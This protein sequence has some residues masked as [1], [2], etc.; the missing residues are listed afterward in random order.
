VNRSGNQRCW[1]RVLPVSAELSHG[2]RA[3]DEARTAVPHSPL[4]AHAGAGRRG[5][6]GSHGVPPAPPGNRTGI[7]QRPRLWE[8]RRR[9]RPV[10]GP[11]SPITRPELSHSRRSQLGSPDGKPCTAP[12]A[13][14]ACRA[15]S[16]G[17]VPAA[18][19]P[20]W[21]RRGLTAAS[22]LPH[23]HERLYALQPHEDAQVTEAL[24]RTWRELIERPL[25]SEMACHRFPRAPFRRFPRDETNS[26]WGT[27]MCAGYFAT[28]DGGVLNECLGSLPR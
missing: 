1:Y 13:L 28:T 18:G 19:D 15:I 12:A 3:T 20:R 25:T 8:A 7:C 23:F 22:R 17:W 24:E 6:G 27:A 9:V 4:G 11:A 16:P 26:R 5:H 10:R 14:G 21:L 2:C